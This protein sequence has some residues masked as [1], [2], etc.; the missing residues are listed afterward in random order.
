MATGGKGRV[1]DSKAP[2]PISFL[3]FSGKRGG[4]RAISNLE[5]LL[6]LSHTLAGQKSD[7]FLL[8][9]KNILTIP[10]MLFLCFLYETGRCFFIFLLRK[11]LVLVCLFRK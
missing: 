4:A 1:L 10:P 6:S 3:S 5:L 11:D 9:L 2:Q 7:L 8:F